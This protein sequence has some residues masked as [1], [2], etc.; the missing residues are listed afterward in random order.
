MCLHVVYKNHFPYYKRHCCGEIVSS[1]LLF[2]WCVFLLSGIIYILILKL[3]Y[4]LL[5]VDGCVLAHVLEFFG[6]P[7]IV[8][9]VERIPWGHMSWQWALWFIGITKSLKRNYYKLSCCSVVTLPLFRAA[10]AARVLIVLLTVLLTR[11]MLVP[12]SPYV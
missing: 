12:F 5:H 3:F 8:V 10:A 1:F 6:F 9:G 4:P 7:I 11:F 2:W